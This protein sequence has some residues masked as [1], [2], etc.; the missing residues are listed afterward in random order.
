M[1]VLLADR[2][3]IKIPGQDEL[4]DLQRDSL[5]RHNVA[6]VPAMAAVRSRMRG[7]LSRLAVEA[8]GLKMR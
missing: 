7:E 4:Y 2:P 3:W 1:L 6:Q 5:E 8:I